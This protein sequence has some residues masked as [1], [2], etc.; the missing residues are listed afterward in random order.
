MVHGVPFPLA[1]LAGLLVCAVIGFINGYVTI[2]FAI[3][4]FITTLGM[5]FIARSLTVVISGGFPPLLPPTCRT[6]C[7]RH[8]SAPAICSACRSCGSPALPSP[9]R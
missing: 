1:L 4:S 2:R 3:P 6:G 7:S 5:L 8:S 9:P